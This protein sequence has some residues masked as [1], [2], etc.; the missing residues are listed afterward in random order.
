MNWQRLSVGVVAV[1]FLISAGL[2]HLAKPSDAAGYVGILVRVGVL[3]SVIWL[4]LPQMEQLKTRL[5][6]FLLLGIMLLLVVVAARPNLSRVAA[7]ILA[8]T[9]AVNWVLKWL[10]RFTNDNKNGK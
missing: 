4:A 7:G 2:I 9:L 5:S 1:G 8:I 6:G 3:L 10:S